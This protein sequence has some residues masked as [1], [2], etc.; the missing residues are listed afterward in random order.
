MEDLTRAGSV[1]VWLDMNQDTTT[2]VGFSAWSSPAD[3]LLQV[4]LQDHLVV[5][6]SPVLQHAGAA[7][8]L[9]SAA[10]LTAG[11]LHQAFAV[12][13]TLDCRTDHAL[14]RTAQTWLTACTLLLGVTVGTYYLLAGGVDIYNADGAADSLSLLR[15]QVKQE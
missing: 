8:V 11:Y 15:W 7:A 13:H 6:Y 4:Q 9:L 14:T 3:A 10:W 1:P 2:T 5:Q 12:H